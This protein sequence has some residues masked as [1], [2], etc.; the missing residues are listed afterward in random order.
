MDI[1]ISVI[2]PMYKVEKYIKECI[3]SVLNQSFKD[4]ELI[5]IDDGSPD[6]S[7]KISDNYQQKDHRIRVVHKKNGGVSAA[8]N[9]GLAICGGQYIYI[10][11]SDDYLASDALYSLYNEAIEKDADV[12]IADHWTFLEKDAPKEQHF[13]SKEFTTVDSKTIEEIQKMILHPNYSPYPTCENMGLGIGAPWTKLIKA[14]LIFDNHLKF[15]SDVKGIF[16]DGLFALYVFQYANKVAYIRKNIY[17]YRILPSSLM[18]GFNPD[19]IGIQNCIFEKIREFIRINK[20]NE[21]F[22]EA[23]SARVVL[24][25]PYLFSTYFFNINYIGSRKENFK[26]FKQVLSNEPYKSAV[27]MV[28]IHTLRRRE[29][30]IVVLMRM[31]MFKLMWCYFQYKN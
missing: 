1:K 12:V 20:K 23:Y 17:Y 13:F 19:R 29:K 18:R 14:R 2:I 8:R 15:D 24:Y 25:I 26:D 10:M 11:D 31:Y 4:F 22:Y 28:N 27:K 6:N 7:G 30:G 9:E 5:L 3:E 16:D 21:C